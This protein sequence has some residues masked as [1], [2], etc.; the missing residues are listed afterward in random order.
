MEKYLNFKVHFCW[1]TVVFTV[2]ICQYFSLHSSICPSQITTIRW[3]KQ[4]SICGAS[5]A[6]FLLILSSPCSRSGGIIKSLIQQFRGILSVTF[7][8][9]LRR[10]KKKRKKINAYLNICWFDL[11]ALASSAPIWQFPG[12]V[13]CGDFYKIV[14][15]DFARSGS[16]C[17]KN[18]RMSWKAIENV[19]STGK[20]CCDDDFIILANARLR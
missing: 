1:H 10:N 16:N 2:F 6:F 13:P 5:L 17:D 8:I 9:I 20:S 4:G 19:S 11:R 18:I 3:S 14:T 15:Q 7:L 12:M